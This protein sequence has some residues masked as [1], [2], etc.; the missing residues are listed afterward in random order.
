MALVYAKV[1]Q[2]LKDICCA[3]FSFGSASV[4][5]RADH[6]ERCRSG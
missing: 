4:I 6:M 1:G 2:E 3:I 5:M